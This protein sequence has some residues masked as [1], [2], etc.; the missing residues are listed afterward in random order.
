MF[1]LTNNFAL[2][3]AQPRIGFPELMRAV[4]ILNIVYSPLLLILHK[5]A[6]CQQHQNV[7]L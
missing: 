5:V 4:G 2:I 3:C 7:S 1:S 6:K